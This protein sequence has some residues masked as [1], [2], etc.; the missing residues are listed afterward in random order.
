MNTDKNPCK[1]FRSVSKK[2]FHT[3]HLHH[4]LCWLTTWPKQ[5]AF[6]FG[7]LLGGFGEH[8]F[9]M[10]A[11]PVLGQERMQVEGAVF[12]V[13]LDFGGFSASLLHSAQGEHHRRF[14]ARTLLAVGVDQPGHEDRHV[15]FSPMPNSAMSRASLPAA[16]WAAVAPLKSDLSRSRMPSKMP[17]P[18]WS[19]AGRCTKRNGSGCSDCTRKGTTKASTRLRCCH[20]Y[21]RPDCGAGRRV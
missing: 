8:I 3:L 11:R 9:P 1:S 17:R 15:G 14:D 19:R 7:A 21:T 20:L 2:V 13:Q 6:Q 10:P 12:A 18:I 4:V 5:A 16:N